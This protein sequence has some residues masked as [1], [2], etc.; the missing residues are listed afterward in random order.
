MLRDPLGGKIFTGLVAIVLAGGLAAAP[1]QRPVHKL[2]VVSIDGLDSRFFKDADRLHIKIPN[3]RKIAATGAIADVIGVAPTTTWPAHAVIATGM[4]PEQNGVLTSDVPGKPGE[5]SWLESDLKATPL[6][7]LASRS[8]L[9]TATVYWPSTVGAHSDFNCPEYWQGAG[10]SSI[11]FDEVA[12]KCTPG[13]IDRISKWDNSFIAS[14]WDDRVGLDVLRYLLANE[15]P[16]LI[17]VHL[18]ELDAEQH[19]TGAMSLYARKLLENDDEMLGTAL[20][21]TGPETLVA[22]VSDH[23][24]DTLNNVVR[25]RVVLKGT[26]VA[27]TVVVRYGLIGTTS[28][29][30][31]A[32]L[33]KSIGVKRSGIAREVPLAEVHRLAPDLR[34]W[35]AAFDTTA[36][37]VATEETRGSAVGVG[38]HKG[39]HG[40]WPTHDNS[41]PIFILS[42]PGVRRMQFGEI[43][44]LDE[45][46]TF[47]EVLGIKLPKGRG[48]SVLGRISR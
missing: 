34:N 19:E 44:M 48:V 11:P 18:A 33:R 42:G 38:S 21:N 27:D 40:L 35:V 24:F 46:P 43:S 3:L 26:G 47:A 23:G 31:A 4:L 25:P 41:R 17:M 29:K 13:L 9:K 30:A 16:D 36:G 28:A 7:S 5:H 37:F 2:I 45:A 14:L 32:I 20:Q 8:G 6:W 15:K 1:V 10:E 12:A 39:I 22:I